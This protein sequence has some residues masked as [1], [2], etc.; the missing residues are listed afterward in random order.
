MNKK[1]SEVERQRRSMLVYGTS[2]MADKSAELE[3]KN[4]AKIDKVQREVLGRSCT[5]KLFLNPEDTFLSIW[6][7]FMLGVIGYSCFTSAYYLAY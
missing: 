4:Q 2:N 6:D 1:T 5:D 7:V 3:F